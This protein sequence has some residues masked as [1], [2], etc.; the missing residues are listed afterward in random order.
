MLKG[1]IFEA[2]W[3]GE[4]IPSYCTVCSALCTTALVDALTEDVENGTAVVTVEPGRH[5]ATGQS[6][7][8]TEQATQPPV[9]SVGYIAS[10]AA[11]DEVWPSEMEGDDARL[12]AD[13]TAGN[14]VLGTD[15]NIVGLDREVTTEDPQYMAE[16]IGVGASPVKMTAGIAGLPMDVRADGIGQ[17][18]DTMTDCVELKAEKIDTA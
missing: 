4:D 8:V 11:D 12:I 9:A 3:A 5:T 13:N 10:N 14:V 7:K 2:H 18:A 16:V 15:N 1:Q 6:A 17:A